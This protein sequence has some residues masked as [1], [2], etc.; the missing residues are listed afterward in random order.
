ML[1]FTVVGLNKQK[2]CP[3]DFQAEASVT[4]D[5]SIDLNV[6]NLLWGKTRQSASDVAANR[7]GR[8]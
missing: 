5:G 4:I 1:R 3:D 8:I 6:A 2:T 7:L